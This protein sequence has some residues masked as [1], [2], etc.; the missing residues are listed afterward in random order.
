MDASQQGGAFFAQPIPADS[1]IMP[2]DISAAL[3]NGNSEIGMQHL[4]ALGGIPITGMGDGTSDSIMAQGPSGP[5]KLSNGEVFF[6]PETVQRLGGHGAFRDFVTDT[7]DQ[8]Q[9][10]LGAFPDPAK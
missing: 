5:I 9:K 6:H 3:G 2:A 1:F 8:F 10:K 4:A 7:R